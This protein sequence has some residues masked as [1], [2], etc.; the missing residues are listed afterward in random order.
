MG[1]CWQHAFTFF[2]IFFFPFYSFFLSFPR[3]VLCREPGWLAKSNAV[4]TITAQIW[5]KCLPRQVAFGV[6]PCFPVLAPV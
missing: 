3:V 4:G 6:A 5:L 1:L 2:F